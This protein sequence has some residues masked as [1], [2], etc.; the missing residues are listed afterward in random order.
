M[1]LNGSKLDSLLSK[2]LHPQFTERGLTPLLGQQSF[3]LSYMT[4]K[5][6]QRVKVQTKAN[7]LAKSGNRKIHLFLEGARATEYDDE[8]PIL[9]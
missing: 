4:S 7:F 3:F 8:I 2:A 6:A 1:C 9:C 5:Q